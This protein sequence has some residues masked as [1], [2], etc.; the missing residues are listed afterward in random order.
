MT[1]TSQLVGVPCT[2]SL[3]GIVRS[4]DQT[5]SFI[6]QFLPAPQQN[7]GPGFAVRSDGGQ[8]V[9][10]RSRDRAVRVELA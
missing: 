7:S 10:H 8:D 1:A 5:I 4:G 3:R 2:R 6:D 9:G